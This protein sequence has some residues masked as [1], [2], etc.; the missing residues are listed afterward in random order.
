MLASLPWFRRGW[1]PISLR[2]ALIDSQDENDRVAT[3]EALAALSFTV[4]DALEANE[5]GGV[6]RSARVK[7]SARVANT[8]GRMAS[9]Q[10]SPHFENGLISRLFGPHKGRTESPKVLH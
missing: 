7:F 10:E 4:A 6:T 3:R 5:L 2:E 9:S 1:M 8:L